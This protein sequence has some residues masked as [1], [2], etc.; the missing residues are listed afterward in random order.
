MVT[1]LNFRGDQFAEGSPAGRQ[2]VCYFR[3]LVPFYYFPSFYVAI[4]LIYG[5]VYLA[6]SCVEELGIYLLLLTTSF[7]TVLLGDLLTFQCHVPSTYQ[8][9]GKTI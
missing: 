5:G 1:I 2:T 4:Q 3:C 8:S 9:T 7:G 6:L